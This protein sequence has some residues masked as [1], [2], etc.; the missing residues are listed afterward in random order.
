MVF[1][2]T[3][4]TNTPC[5]T[6]M[7]SGRASGQAPGEPRWTPVWHSPSDRD[8]YVMTPA[9]TPHAWVAEGSEKVRSAI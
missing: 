4:E 1:R 2:H 3:S 8:G 6:K 5:Q 7:E 9:Y